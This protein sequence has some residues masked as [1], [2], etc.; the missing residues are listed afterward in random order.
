MCSRPLRGHDDFVHAQ[1]IAEYTLMLKKTAENK[2]IA[3]RQAAEMKKRKGHTMKKSGSYRLLTEELGVSPEILDIVL[4]AEKS[5]SEQFREL[6]DIKEYNQYKVLD[7]FRKCRISDVHFGW[8]T[9]YGYDDAG[10]EA[11]EKVYAG[12][13]HTEDAIVRPLIVNG[14]HALT[15]TLT[16]VLRPGDELVYCTGGPYDTLEEV[17][18]IRGEGKGSLKEFGVTYRQVDLLP[19]GRIDIEGCKSVINEHTKMMCVQRATGY[20]WRKAIQV[21]EISEWAAAVKSVRSDI[22]T[23]ADNCYGEFLDT[24]E[25]TDVGVDI[26]AGSLIKNPGGGLA[27]SG[28]YIVGRHDLIENVAYRMTSPGIGKECG[29][30]FGQS[31]SMFQGLFVAP[32]VVNGAL[33]GAMLCARVFEMLGY[34]VCPASGDE[35]SDI[36]EAVRL[37]S[38]E[39]ME[40]FCRGIQSAAPVDSFVTPVPWDMPGYDDQVIMA[41]GAFVQGSSIELSADG[42]IRDPYIVYFQG[43]LTYEHSKY[44][45]IKAVQSLY[46]AGLLKGMTRNEKTGNKDIS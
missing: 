16:G 40:A 14:T 30:T 24:T 5:L 35:R 23:M 38:P 9:G 46:D 31:R 43:G 42:P 32:S 11:L 25:P 28:G 15:L 37:E 3:G 7:V 44:G 1:K 22:I 10:R 26:M 13:F 19:D 29:L 18:G 41:A 2:I 27:L 39:A 36:I 17:I 33:K 6:D 20:A 21:S 45:V 12:V 34:A 4:E 8:N